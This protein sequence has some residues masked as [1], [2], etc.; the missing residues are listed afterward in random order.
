MLQRARHLLGRKVATLDGELGSVDDVHFH[1]DD[2][3]VRQIVVRLGVWPPAR[4]IVLTTDQLE[5]A[6]WE[7]GTIRLSTTSSQLKKQRLTRLDAPVTQQS[8]IELVHID[9]QTTPPRIERVRLLGGDRNLL[10]VREILGY[11]LS[12]ADERFGRVNDLVFDPDDMHVRFLV[13]LPTR[14]FIGRRRMLETSHCRHVSWLEKAVTVDMP[15]KELRRSPK[16][17]SFPNIH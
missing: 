9:Q 13:V 14:W 3:T 1:D 6:T 12:K 7:N 5:E 15:R 16:L 17:K 8:K 11:R 2:W 10:S 4:R